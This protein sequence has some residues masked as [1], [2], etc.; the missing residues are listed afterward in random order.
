MAFRR[1]DLD[2]G[3]NELGSVAHCTV[4]WGDDNEVKFEISKTRILG[5]QQAAPS[6]SSKQRSDWSHQRTGICH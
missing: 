5:L 1:G 3:L 6:A 4:K 2:E